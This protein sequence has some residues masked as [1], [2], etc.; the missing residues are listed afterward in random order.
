MRISPVQLNLYLFTKVQVTPAEA[1]AFSSDI[2]PRPIN[3]DQVV[4]GAKIDFGWAEQDEKDR[5]AFAVRLFLTI[6]NEQGTPSPYLVELGVM[7]FFTLLGDIP[8]ED[9]ENI[10]KV[11]GA[12]LLYGVLREML[13]GLTAR[14]PAGPAILPS[15]NFLD[16]KTSSAAEMTDASSASSK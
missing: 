16:L 11:N 9:R 4:F 3:W 8:N 10:A 14:F 2:S 7:G 5:R 6:D 1:P 12:S 13:F 15:M